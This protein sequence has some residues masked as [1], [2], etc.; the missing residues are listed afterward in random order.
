MC[1]IG[2]PVTVDAALAMLDRAL[3]ALNATDM[4]PLPAAVQAAAL[5]GLE[6]AEAKHTAARTG[7]L[8]AFTAQSGYT[9]D[10]QGSTRQ[11]LT[12]Q[13]R[14]TR[15]AAASSMAWL[16]R[17]AAHPL[18]GQALAAGEISQSW[19]REFCDWN[20]RLPADRHEDADAI[21]LAAARAGADRPALMG[22][23]WEMYERSRGGQPDTDDGFDDRYL[24]LGITFGGAGRCEGD[25]TPGCAA[26]LSAVLDALA[27]KAGPED[28]RTA[29]QRRHDAL[30]EACRRLIASG[31]LPA[32]GGQPTQAQLH[33]TLAQLRGLPGASAAEAAWRA[34]AAQDYGWLSGPEA[35][36]T[37]CDA[38]FAP[39][40]TGHVDPAALDRLVA[41]LLGS[42]AGTTPPAE[43]TPPTAT[44]DRVRGAVLAMAADVLS[45]PG[46]LAAWL[47]SSALAGGPGATPS[48]PLGVPLPLDL[49]ETEPAIPAHLRRAVASRHPH[50]AFP[51]CDQ[52]ASVCQVHHLVPRAEGGPTTLANLVPLCSFHHLI[53]IHRWGWTLV[54]HPDGSTTAASPGRAGVLH[55]HGPPGRAA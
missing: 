11:W 15:G 16:R 55:S 32:R 43:A 1:D 10:G 9:D 26:A 19:A 53:V 45:G 35:D 2:R 25:L 13:T 40:V 30:E 44:L 18:I 47:R 6:R 42:H 23:A 27:K 34:A 48:L 20:D 21:L 51:G 36:A 46:G 22:L 8:A 37:G 14:V 3:D 39:V 24:R 54:L 31:M 28:I 52:P 4:G 49:G 50:C 33:I 5:R 7:V 12:W 38:T 41:V 29:A 17:L